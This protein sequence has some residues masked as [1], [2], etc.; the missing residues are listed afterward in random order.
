MSKYS[1]DSAKKQGD[2][3]VGAA[4]AILGTLATLAIKKTVSDKCSNNKKEQIANFDREINDID[5]QISNLKSGLLGSLINSVQIDRLR[6]KRN[7]FIQQRN[8]LIKK[9]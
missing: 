7:S 8:N 4:I 3:S 2:A 9:K 5:R 1:R 6:F